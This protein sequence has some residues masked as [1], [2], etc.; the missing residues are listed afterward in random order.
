MSI[1]TKY[2]SLSP[3]AKKQVEAFLDFL[4][5]NQQESKPINAQAWKEKIKSIPQWSEEDVDIFDENARLFN[6]WP[7]TTW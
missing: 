5:S 4:L 3:E 6:Q 2:Q 7:S 1:L